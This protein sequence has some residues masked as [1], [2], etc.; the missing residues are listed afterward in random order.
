MWAQDFNTLEALQAKVQRHRKGYDHTGI[1]LGIVVSLSSDLF[2]TVH[3]RPNVNT[4]LAELG[5]HR[6]LQEDQE[7]R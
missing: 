3:V 4:R 1:I 2:S 6:A 5:R 7:W